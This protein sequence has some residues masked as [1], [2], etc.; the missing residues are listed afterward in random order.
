MKI[1]LIEQM[2]KSNIHVEKVLRKA[3]RNLF[4]LNDENMTF[5]Y[6]VF[7]CSGFGSI[8]ERPY[9]FRGEEGIRDLL[10]SLVER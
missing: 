2:L 4:R 1:K 6:D 3:S 5:N 7:F 8:R 10:R 9:A